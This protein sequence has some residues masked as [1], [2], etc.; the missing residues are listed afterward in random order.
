[1]AVADRASDAT[2]P[3]EHSP[4]ML[5]GELREWLNVALSESRP[6]RRAQQCLARARALP[7]AR[8]RRL[9][10]RAAPPEPWQRKRA[11]ITP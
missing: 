8:E 2:T 1:V 11:V 5:D 3:D 9:A 7:G 6:C 4:T 10:R